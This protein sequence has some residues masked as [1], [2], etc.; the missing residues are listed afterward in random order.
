MICTMSR[1]MFRTTASILSAIAA[2]SLPEP[3][4]MI[5]RGVHPSTFATRSRA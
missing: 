3:V 2:A 1:S 4:K 5:S